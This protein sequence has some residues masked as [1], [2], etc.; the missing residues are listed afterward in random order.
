MSLNIFNI[1]NLISSYF[2][3]VMNGQRTLFL[4]DTISIEGLVI[5]K[6]ICVFAEATLSAHYLNRSGNEYHWFKC[7]S[8]HACCNAVRGNQST[9]NLFPIALIDIKSYSFHFGR[10][11]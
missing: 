4:F 10:A 8:S 9:S 2:V 6:A 5:L 3:G 7:T 1:Y 11:Y